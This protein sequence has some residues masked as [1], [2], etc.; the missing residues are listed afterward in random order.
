MI[1]ARL[2]KKLYGTNGEFEL[3]AE[4]K[5][6]KGEFLVVFGP[7]GAG[8]TTLLRLIAGLERPEEGY[9]LVDGSVW[10]D[11]QKGINLPPYKRSVG[12]VFQD[13]ALFPNM[14][15]LKNVMYGMPKK[16]KSKAV[17]LLKL[18]GMEALKDRK[19]E[20]LS[21][22]QRQRVALLRALARE[23]QVL[24]LDEP[25]SALDHNLRSSLR[26]EI[27][28]FQKR[29]NTTAIMVSHHLADALELADRVLFIKEGKL[30]REATPQELVEERLKGKLVSS[31]NGKYILELSKEELSEILELEEATET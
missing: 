17:E 6:E 15:V 16:D 3:S 30:I 13:Y 28:A 29:F 8:K 10:L 26:K 4:L 21:G 23:P 5:V 31:K 27:K 20:S 2:K 7:S 9:I 14:T 25:L 12:F 1:Q 22:G 18:A 11:T 24:L 19:P